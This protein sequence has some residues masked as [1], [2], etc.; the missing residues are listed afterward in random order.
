MKRQRLGRLFGAEIFVET[1]SDDV[2]RECQKWLETMDMRYRKAGE[3]KL[4]T[5][6]ANL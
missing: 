2:A 3:E 5:D 6:M 1:D 4:L